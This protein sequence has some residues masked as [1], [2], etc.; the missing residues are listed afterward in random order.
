MLTVKSRGNRGILIAFWIAV[1]LFPFSH[2]RTVSAVCTVS[3]APADFGSYD[4][5]LTVAQ[6]IVTSITVDCN[7]APPVIATISV[8]PSPNSGGFDPRQMKLS[9]GSEFINYNLYV[10]PGRTQIWGDGSGSTFTISNKVTKNKS[11]IASIYGRIPPGQDV[12]VGTYSETL[13]V[14]IVW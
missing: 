6:D 1:T 13:T 7:E 3:T 14:V 2:A 12:S 8:G 9:G 5:L 11:W 4:V 10:D